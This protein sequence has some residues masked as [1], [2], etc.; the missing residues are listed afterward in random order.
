MG[1]G[2]EWQAK[3]YDRLADPHEAWAEAILDRLSPGPGERV[4]DAGCGSGRITR[5]LCGRLADASAGG[6]AD[7]SVLAVDA[8]GAMLDAAR[9]SLSEFE[10]HVEFA[11]SDLLGLRDAPGERGRAADAVFSC[12]VF[13]WIHDH[14]ALFGRIHSWLRPGGR[15]VAQCGGAGN[16]AEWEEATRAAVAMPRF[17]GHFDGWPGPWNFAGPDETE[18]RLHAAGFHEVRCWLEEKVTPVADGRAYLE[19]VGLAVHLDRLPA[20]AHEPFIDAVMQGV[21]DPNTLLY[22]RLNIDARRPAEDVAE[23]VSHLE[24]RS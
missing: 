22:V 20:E 10:P 15:L 6:D 1:D 19:V 17:R 18:A 24:V 5:G 7:W 12:A 4:V 13:H 21:S 8:S 23:G 3:R 2:V 14:E 11:R 9:E 16:V